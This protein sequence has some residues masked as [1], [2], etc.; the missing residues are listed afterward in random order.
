MAADAAGADA[1]A[2]LVANA[3]DVEHPRIERTPAE[4][5]DPDSDLGNRLVTVHVPPLPETAVESALQ[6]GVEFALTLRRSGMIHAAAL[7]LQG[8][9][10]LLGD[11]L[12]RVVAD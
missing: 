11:G 4:E 6:R 5:L 1:A 2:T 8:R 9:W 3:V 7:A 12:V 10:R